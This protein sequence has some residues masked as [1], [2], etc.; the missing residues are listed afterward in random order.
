MTSHISCAPAAGIASAVESL[1]A[2]PGYLVSVWGSFVILMPRT[3][4]TVRILKP[5]DSRG[6][7]ARPVFW[8]FTAKT[9]IRPLSSILD[10]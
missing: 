6:P 10:A 8:L 7:N 5:N 9:V 3:Y 2:E 4:E 1:L